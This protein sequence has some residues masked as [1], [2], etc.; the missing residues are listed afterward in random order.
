MNPSR[1]VGLSVKLRGEPL[2][3]WTRYKEYVGNELWSI[4]NDKYFEIW[5]FYT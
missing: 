4:Y 2:N 3:I 5:I 1:V